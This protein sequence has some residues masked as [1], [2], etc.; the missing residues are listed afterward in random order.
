MYKE[1]YNNHI[2]NFNSCCEEDSCN[3]NAFQEI[4]VCVPITIEPYVDLG[5]A[6]VECIDEPCISLSHSSGACN[7]S[8]ACKFTIEQKLCVMVPIEFKATA[9]SGPTSVICGDASDEDCQSNNCDENFEYNTD[10]KKPYR[11]YIRGK[12][13]E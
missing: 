2:D 4:D 3:V 11:F 7:K 13:I 9:K 5:E 1:N 6:V 10:L 8:G 12:K